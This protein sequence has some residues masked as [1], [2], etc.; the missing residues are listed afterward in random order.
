MPKEIERKFLVTHPLNYLDDHPH[1]EI[2]QGY[3][4]NSDQGI[5]VRLRKKAGRYYKTVKAGKGLVRDE[6]EIELNEPQFK[7]L[8]PLTEGRRI[9]KVRYK[10]P[11]KTLVIELDVFK[12]RLAGLIIAEVEFD[13]IENC[14]SFSG[15]QWIGKDVTG[16]P[17]FSNWSLATSGLPKIQAF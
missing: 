6:V 4:N 13:N 17:Q 12:G 8:W 16:K 10:I 11:Y 3:L 5:E 1:E 15:P 2:Q 7:R 14:R 9:H